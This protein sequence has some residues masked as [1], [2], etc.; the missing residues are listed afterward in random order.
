MKITSTIIALLISLISFGQIEQNINKT[1]GTVSNPIAEIDS[2][3]FNAG[4]TEM[5]VVFTNGNVESHTIADIDEVT[6]S[7]ELNLWPEGTVHCGVPTEI[8]DVTNPITGATWMDRN[9]GAAQVASSSTDPEAYGDLY[10]WG[11][12]ADGHQCRNS[13]TTSDL[14]TT[15]Q[16]EHGFFIISNTGASLDWRSPQND[17]LWQGVNGVNNPC[18]NGYRLPTGS[19]LNAELTSWSSNNAAGAFASPLKLTMAGGRLGSSPG[20]LSAV[21][22]RGVYWSSE[23]SSNKSLSFRFGSDEAE[24]FIA[25]RSMARSVRCIKD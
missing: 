25:Y 12:G 18:P 9:L 1:S 4:Q 20:L 10:Q 21:N 17:N 16:P 24:M 19:E 22:V 11:R 7:G 6:F 5:E 2:I 23:V 8:V 15:D 14:S 13:S 3:R